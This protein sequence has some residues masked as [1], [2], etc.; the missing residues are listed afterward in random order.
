MKKHNKTY[1]ASSI[2]SL[3]SKTKDLCITN[4]KK[5]LVSDFSYCVI[6]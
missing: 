4:E 2:P 3:N 1:H 5:L 6:W